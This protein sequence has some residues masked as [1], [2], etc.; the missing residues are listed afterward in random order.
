[1]SKVVFNY[2]ELREDVKSEWHKQNIAN[3]N[4]EKYEKWKSEPC[5]EHNEHSVNQAMIAG[6]QPFDMSPDGEEALQEM[7][8]DEMQYNIDTS[9]RKSLEK[10]ADELGVNHSSKGKRKRKGDRLM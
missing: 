2:T 1:M 9:D 4:Y 3:F 5:S 8:N 10:L 6:F 7:Y